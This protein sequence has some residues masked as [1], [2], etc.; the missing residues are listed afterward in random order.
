MVVAAPTGSGKTVLLELAICRLA[1]D[2]A[3]N[4]SK[5]VYIGPT[6][7]LCK[8]KTEDW[9]KKFDMLNM[10]VVELT[11][12]TSRAEMRNVREAKVIVTT[13]EKWDSITRSWSDH[14]KLLQM[15]ELFLI[16]E[17]HILRESR[18]ATLEAIVSRM[19]TYGSKVR[20]I[21]LSATVPNSED[22]ARWLGKDHINPETPAQRKVFGEEHRPVKLLRA[23]YGFDSKLGD[24][25]FDSYLNGQ[26][27]KHLEMHSEK[28]PVLVFCMTRKSCQDAAAELAKQWGQRQPRDRLWPEPK[29]RIPVVDPQLQELVRYGVAFHHAGLDTEDR[30]A[31][32]RAFEEGHISVICCTSTLAVGINLPCHTVVL[33]GT[34][35]YQDG[36]QLS[37]YSDL[38]VMQ[39]LGRAGRPQ[40]GRSA[41]VIILTRS[42]NKKRY[43]ELESGKQILESTLHKNLIEHL[44]SELSLGTFTDVD[45][46]K[47][48][49]EGTFLSVRLRR[50]PAYYRQLTEATSH[51][52]DSMTHG[53]T[54][55][56]ICYSALERL[57]RARLIEGVA[58]LQSTEY[59]RVMSKYMIRYD[60]MKTIMDIPQG[61][62]LRDL[63]TSLC[64]ASE[65]S[66]IRWQT[67]E[68]E[69]FRD[70][71]KDHF[72]LF[73]IAGTVS[74]VAHK[75]SL[76]IQMELGRV[77]PSS[78]PGLDRRRLR[79]ETSRVFEVM[80]RLIRAVIE[81]KG[82]DMDGTTCWASLD[83]ARSMVA[84]AWEGKTVQLLQVPQVGVVLM[85]K[86]VCSNIKSVA[87]LA[88]TD[89]GTIE[90]I[91]SRNPPFGK[92]MVDSLSTFPKLT[93]HAKIKDRTIDT[94]GDTILCVDASLGFTSSFGKWNGKIPILTFLAVTTAGV[95]AYF[96]RDSLT[97]LQSE[98]EGRYQVYFTWSPQ[99]IEEE[100]VCRLA[101]EDIV[102]TVVSSVVKHD[103]PASSFPRGKA[104]GNLPVAKA[105]GTEFEGDS[106]EFVQLSDRIDDEDIANFL[107]QT[108]NILMEEI[109][110]A[111]RTVEGSET[112]SAGTMLANGRYRCAHSCS[113]VDGGKTTRGHDC[114]HDCCRNGSKRPPKKAP[115][116][117]KRKES[118]TNAPPTNSTTVWDTSKLKPGA[119]RAKIV[120]SVSSQQPTQKKIRLLHPRKL[121]F[122]E[123]GM[124]DLTM[125]D[126]QPHRGTSE[127]SIAMRISE[128]NDAGSNFFDNLPD[129][130]LLAM[131]DQIADANSQRK[132]RRVYDDVQDDHLGDVSRCTATEHIQEGHNKHP[133]KDVWH[134]E[135]VD[136]E[137]GV[138][139][140]S[141]E[142]MCLVPAKERGTT[143]DLAA[144]KDS[145]TRHT[146][147][148]D[149]LYEFE[150]GFIDE[151]RGLVDFK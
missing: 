4:N 96:W 133:Y 72:I 35:G 60:T 128:E 130:D 101:C 75:V 82:A 108:E 64:E 74:T 87:S 117:A 138:E 79:S 65:F 12:D 55:R 149:W 143:R 88:G 146:E 8:E 49:L 92:K 57:R 5:I 52:L 39:M 9:T 13:P 53:G 127:N 104:M 18:G 11:G 114:G 81:C 135:S 84:R 70:L 7:A 56:H 100:L 48:W 36:G 120:A 134:D 136:M 86:F 69:L 118:G 131:T 66:E 105:G 102:G 95:S 41:F 30:K 80:H 78:V 23:V 51:N 3:N 123:D 33:K 125:E 103:L 45:G 90:R 83:L 40:F 27:W 26:L 54:L 89:T 29:R 67:N 137:D 44:N 113:Q 107:D 139:N 68:K 119:K 91:A 10:P 47:T 34:V 16:D 106:L 6:K 37:E 22:I 20:F 17:V 50:N 124:I 61:T 71:N 140:N 73:P 25:A 121:E 94:N 14:R 151:F 145:L 38:E 141:Q 1:T 129:D 46:A 93:L 126:V 110:A 122:D 28:K 144:P 21:A 19:K 109:C 97:V 116:G 148:P 58:N 62:K 99:A 59:G 111:E 98:E 85:R 112:I 43:E 142:H 63:L 15:V 31:V 32:H 2:T 132:C 76:L 115:N 147:E 42:R 24:Y 77:E 150:A